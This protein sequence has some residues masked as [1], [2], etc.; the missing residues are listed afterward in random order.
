VLTVTTIYP[1]QLYIHGIEQATNLT[2]GSETKVAF[3]AAPSGR[4]FL[5][6]HGKDDSH[7][8]VAVLEVAPR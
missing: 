4:Y 3:T 6:L 1:G 2:P 5:H 8:E 7:T